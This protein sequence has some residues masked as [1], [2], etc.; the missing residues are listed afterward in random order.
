VRKEVEEQERLD[1]EA[2]NQYREKGL[3]LARLQ[4]Y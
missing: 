1:Q 2:T 4:H 3:D